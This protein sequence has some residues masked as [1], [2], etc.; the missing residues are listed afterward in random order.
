V[1]LT[2]EQLQALEEAM[3]ADYRRLLDEVRDELADRDEQQYSELVNGDP[4][5][6]GDASVA[7]LLATLNLAGVDRH[8]TALRDIEAA[9]ARIKDG[10]YGRCIECG[11]DIEYERLRAYPTAKRCRTDQELRERLYQRGSTPTM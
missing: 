11:R 9:R 10:S 8:I 2:R 5:D 6:A 1:A 7:D 4:T 3:D